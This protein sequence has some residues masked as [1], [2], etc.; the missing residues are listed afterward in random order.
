V[1]TKGTQKRLDSFFGI[2]KKKATPMKDENSGSLKKSKS[3]VAKS[4]K[5]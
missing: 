3:G 4:S 1:D 5:K 2:T